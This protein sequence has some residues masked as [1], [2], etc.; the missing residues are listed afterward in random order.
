MTTTTN[1]SSVPYL[2]LDILLRKHPLLDYPG[3]EELN[4]TV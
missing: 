3:T 1:K 2:Y 4:A